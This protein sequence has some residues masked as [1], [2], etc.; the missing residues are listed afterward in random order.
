MRTE[1]PQSVPS[2]K[3]TSPPA[4]AAAEPFDEPPG[5]RPGALHVHRRAEVHVL[6]GQAVAKLVAMGL[7]GHV[8][9]GGE[10]PLHRLGGFARRPDACAASRAG[11]SR[12]ARPRCRIY[13]WRRRSARRAG[14]IRNPSARHGSRGRTRRADRSAGCVMARTAPVRPPRRHSR[15][16]RAREPRRPAS[17][18][19][20]GTPAAAGGIIAMT[21]REIEALPGERHEVETGRNRA[22]R[23]P[24]IGAAGADRL[25]DIR[26]GRGGRRNGIELLELISDW[27]SRES[28]SSCAPAPFGRSAMRARCRTT[29]ARVLRRSGLPGAKQALFAPREADQ[30]GI[31]DCAAPAQH[32]DIGIALA[33]KRMEMQRGRD[34]AALLEARKAGF[35]AFR[36][37]RKPRAALRSAHSSSGSW[38][39]PTIGAGSAAGMPFGRVRFA[40]SQRSSSDCGNSHL[41]VTLV[42]G[43]A[44]S[45]TSSSSLRSF[46]ADIRRLPWW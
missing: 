46:S 18:R 28:N 22:R 27:R 30:H 25:R 5:T 39:P 13:P 12:C 36:Q 6:A 44:S 26:A 37:R 3:S 41:P 16:A 29:S 40:A 35:A 20:A 8:G 9:A 10:Q 43:I 17:L 45:A 15:R 2:A 21:H 34:D 7:A 24:A 1:P 33:G 11:R 4:T 19:S 32:V 42:H 14:P 23:D 31:G 38:L